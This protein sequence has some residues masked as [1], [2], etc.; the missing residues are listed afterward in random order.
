MII[1]KTIILYFIQ[2]TYTLIISPQRVPGLE[3][4][5][6]RWIPNRTTV[7]LD[8]LHDLYNIQLNT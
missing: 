3:V 6:N 5:I 8:Y 4:L 7:E 1:I 2:I